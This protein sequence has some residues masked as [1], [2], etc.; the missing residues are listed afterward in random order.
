MT[1]QGHPAGSS[2]QALHLAGAPGEPAQSPGAASAELDLASVDH[3][4]PRNLKK[5]KVHHLGRQ[6]DVAS[7]LLQGLRREHNPA[8]GEH[9]ADAELLSDKAVTV[10]R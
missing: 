9:L 8:E 4:H 5:N 7:V 10:S 6:H 2:G 3:A 1:E